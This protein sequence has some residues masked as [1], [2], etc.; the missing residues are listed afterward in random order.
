MPKKNSAKKYLWYGTGLL[1]TDVL[2]VWALD[3][4]VA[5]R[6]GGSVMQGLPLA[7]CLLHLVTIGVLAV[8]MIYRKATREIFDARALA[9]E[10]ELQSKFSEH[11]CGA[12][13]TAALRPLLAKNALIVE[14]SLIQFL[15]CVK[16]QGREELGKLAAALGFVQ[17]WNRACTSRGA[18]RRR[19][20]V[21]ALSLMP[22]SIGRASLR[23]ALHDPDPE[24]QVLASRAL[25]QSGDQEEIQEIFIL[26]LDKTLR[27]RACLTEDFRRH[28]T[29]L[30]ATAVPKVLAAGNRKR[31]LL[32]CEMLG[33]WR[34]S[35]HLEGWQQMF[36]G[37][38]ESNRAIVLRL[39]PYVSTP[40]EAEVHV[41]KALSDEDQE[42]KITAANIAGH[43]ELST[44]IPL[45]STLLSDPRSEVNR[46]A[47]QALSKLGSAGQ[48]VL[49]EAVLG[50]M[51]RAG[52]AALEALEYFNTGRLTGTAL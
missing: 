18:E 33:A 14:Y 22:L 41:V 51:R 32:M 17:K 27:V 5:I 52:G 10:P 37:S 11:A 46:A 21:V 13:Q 8:V 24:I 4:L 34:R 47:A 9:L 43:W 12:D 39:L 50:H 36:E 28:A 35:I 31:I 30:C 1:A 40:D 15:P 26:S 25:V 20:G 3:R 6:N 44:T 19:A 23:N 49:E 45:L 48:R 38:S 7:F 42:V 16:G 29:V 2:L